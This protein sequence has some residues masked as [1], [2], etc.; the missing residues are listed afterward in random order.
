MT[1]I[2][3]L[4]MSFVFSCSKDDKNTNDLVGTS[5]I[6]ED[7]DG[8]EVIVFD[9][10]NTFIDT[11]TDYYDGSKETARGTYTYQ[12]PNVTLIVYYQGETFTAKGKVSGNTLV[13]TNED[14]DT[15]IFFKQ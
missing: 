15:V 6:R 5:W 14:G 4:A 3:L 10:E 1:M 7:E 11:Y 13:L 2:A 8:K 9:S 12:K